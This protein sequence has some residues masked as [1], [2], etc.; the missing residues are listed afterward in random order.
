MINTNE[1]INFYPNSNHHASSQITVSKRRGTVL[2]HCH[3]GTACVC[4]SCFLDR[5]RPYNSRI[6]AVLRQSGKS[7]P[8][9]YAG[10]AARHWHRSRAPGARQRAGIKQAEGERQE[11]GSWCA[12]MHTAAVETAYFAALPCSACQQVHAC[13]SSVFHTSLIFSILLHWLSV[14][15]ASWQAALVD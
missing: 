3:H 13:R 9:R 4:F 10:S 1:D 14:L 2:G 6:A 7:G 15:R 8:L 5:K 12:D 11:L